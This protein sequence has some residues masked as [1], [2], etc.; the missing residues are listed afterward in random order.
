M[1][2]K[3][4]EKAKGEQAIFFGTPKNKA[5]DGGQGEDGKEGGNGVKKGSG[6]FHRMGDIEP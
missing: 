4:K 1:V 5:Q 2:Q 3:E 6:I